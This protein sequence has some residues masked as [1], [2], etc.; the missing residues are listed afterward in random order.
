[1]SEEDQ[2]VAVWENVWA[3]STYQPTAVLED[4]GTVEGYRQFR[5]FVPPQA[6]LILEAGCGTGRFCNLL[7]RDLP[8]CKVIGIDLSASALATARNGKEVM[9][10][11]NVSFQTASLF[12]LPFPDNHFDFVFNEGVIQLFPPEGTLTDRDAIREM[13]RV[14]RPGGAV[15]VSVVNW[16][17]FPH[18]FYKWR[19]RH[20]RVHYEYG[21]EKSYRPGELRRLFHAAGLRHVQFA[22]FYPAYGFYR[23]SG[24]LRHGRRTMRA[25]GA[26]VDRLDCPW[27]SRIFGFE[28]IAVGTK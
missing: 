8:H 3:H 14:T 6:R 7:G 5:S 24:R 12:A 17:C 25:L 10:C 13:V 9:R 4:R 26:L 11:E 22:G 15:L 21:Y 27:L 23:L 18:T 16:A 20:G 2:Y 19:L 1:M 28:I